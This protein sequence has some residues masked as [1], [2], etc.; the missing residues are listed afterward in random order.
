MALKIITTLKSEVSILAEKR[1][2]AKY[3]FV[4]HKFNELEEK[5]TC[6]VKTLKQL[7]ANISSGS[8][9]DKYLSKSEGVPYIRVGN[10]KPFSISEEETNLVYVSKNL[11]EKIKVKENDII[12][13]RTQA[14]VAKLAVASIID[15]KNEGCVLSQHISKIRVNE[16]II[17]PFYL[18]GYFNSKFYKAQTA[19]ATHGDTRVELT[20]SQLNKIRI[21]IPEKEV[22]KTIESK[23][24]KIID[25]NR[26]SINKIE[27]AQSI[28]GKKLNIDISKIE[29]KIFYSVNLSEFKEDDLWTPA[30]SYPLY[31]NTLK[32]IQNTCSL[33]P[34]GEIATV[35]KGN[36]VGSANYNIALDKNDGDIPFIRTS[37]L[38]NHEV[39]Q[40][41]DYYISKDIYDELKQDIKAGDI[42]FNN[43]GKIGLVAILTEQDNVIIQSHIKRLRLKKEAKKYNLTPEYLFLALTIKEV[44]KIQ[45]ERYTVI[46]ST[47]PTISNHILDIKIPILDNGSIEEITKLV[48]E[49][50]EL[51]NEKK[52]LINEIKEQIDFYFDI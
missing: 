11:P 21:F 18:I 5:S 26:H 49:A 50:F 41:P 29:K 27:K 46:Q 23:V 13:G 38:V 25:V 45:V 16:N 20:H 9:V 6:E 37:D 28:F 42:L 44:A 34:I 22:L 12:M 2:D 39:D 15:K 24:K 47:I 31:V 36:E 3:F 48:K 52:R 8:Y 4:N 1:L 17:S 51:K 33:V 7:N 32:A 30:F 10:I 19:L 14:T 40:F 43:D 35:K